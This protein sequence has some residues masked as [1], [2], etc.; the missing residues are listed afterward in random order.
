MTSTQTRMLN[1]DG[2]N[3]ELSFRNGKLYRILSNSGR[4]ID[5]RGVHGRKIAEA[6]LVS[7]EGKL[8][9]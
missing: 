8:P 2:K 5:M 7:N 4:E 9:M 1:V 6:Y 3:Y